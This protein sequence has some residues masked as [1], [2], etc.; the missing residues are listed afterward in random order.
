M[1]WPLPFSLLVSC[2][3]GPASPYLNGHLQPLR[4]YPTEM[5]NYCKFIVSLPVAQPAT[6]PDRILLQQSSV[7]SCRHSFSRRTCIESIIY[8][9]GILPNYIIQPVACLILNVLLGSCRLEGFVNELSQNLPK[10]QVIC[11][12]RSF[13]KFEEN[14]F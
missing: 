10:L 11:D 4:P 14:K 3:V 12:V 2:G 5:S 6:Q 9:L 8:S 13:S 1:V 7:P